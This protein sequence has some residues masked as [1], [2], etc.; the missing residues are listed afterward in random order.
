MLLLHDDHLDARRAA[1]AGPLAGLADSL[2]RDLEPL[3][4][5]ALYVPV[6]KALLSRAGGRCER[7]GTML[8]FDP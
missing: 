7:D 3:R 4:A 5:R 2:A 6:E 1:A 8:E